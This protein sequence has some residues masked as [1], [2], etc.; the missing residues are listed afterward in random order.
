[1]LETTQQESSLMEKDLWV[2]LNSKLVKQQRT[3]V[4]KVSGILGCI[5]KVLPAGPEG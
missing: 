5:S 2:L 1:M 3:L 4:V